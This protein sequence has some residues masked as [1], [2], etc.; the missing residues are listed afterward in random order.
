ME[1]EKEK[2]RAHHTRTIVKLKFP[3]DY[4]LE[5]AFGQKEL[6]KDLYEFV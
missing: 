3:D 6:V 2:G 1:L 4:I 5:A